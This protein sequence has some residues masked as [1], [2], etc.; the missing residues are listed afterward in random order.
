MN[1]RL[2]LICS[3]LMNIVTQ[4][5]KNADNPAKAR[6]GI[7]GLADR[8]TGKATLEET[9]EAIEYLL[10]HGHLNKQGQY[11]VGLP[12]GGENTW[13]HEYNPFALQA[14]SSAVPEKS[15]LQKMQIARP[16]E[17]AA[18]AM[19]KSAPRQAT[20]KPAETAPQSLDNE[21][22]VIAAHPIEK[23]LSALKARLNVKP[24]DNLTVKLRTLDGLARLLDPEIS[25]VL[26]Q[27]QDDLREIAR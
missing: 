14:N 24:I 17:T 18:P 5:Y 9:A 21:A 8:L 26:N 4:T 27:I 16:E 11:C 13:P 12:S 10:E 23:S 19:A 1:T 3:E 6:F 20:P 15:N 7:K 2:N 25:S 22:T